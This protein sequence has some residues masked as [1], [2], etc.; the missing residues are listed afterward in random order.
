MAARQAGLSV[1]LGMQLLHGLLPPHA[2]RRLLQYTCELCKGTV[3]Q[4]ANTTVCAGL[5]LLAEAALGPAHSEEGEEMAGGSEEEEE[6]SNDSDEEGELREESRQEEDM[7][8]EFDECMAESS[9]EVGRI[10]GSSHSVS[11]LVT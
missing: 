7:M 3:S 5:N 2:H 8:D 4:E 11:L 10:E 9:E 1:T 6:V